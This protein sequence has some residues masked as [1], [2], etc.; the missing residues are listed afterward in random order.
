MSEGFGS[1]A[2]FKRCNFLKIGPIKRS[3]GA[4][5]VQG[6][7]GFPIPRFLPREHML[8]RLWN[9]NQ[10]NHELKEDKLATGVLP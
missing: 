2:I 9:Q 4:S 6:D 3:V 7:T 1:D 8:H 10:G 5:E